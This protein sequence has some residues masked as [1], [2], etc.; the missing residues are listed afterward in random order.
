MKSLSEWVDALHMQAHPEGG[1]YA[2]VYRS[3]GQ[4]PQNALPEQFSGPRNYGTSIYFL[5]GPE[6]HSAFHRLQADEIWHFYAG[7]RL[8]VYVIHPNGN[9]QTLVLGNASEKGEVF[10]AVVPAGTWFAAQPVAGTY[11][12]VGCT[13]APGFDFEDFELAAK[14]D[15]SQEYPQ[16][17]DL[18]ARLS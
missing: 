6:D 12:L 17:A 5:L 14:D 7:G 15:L 8:E 9:L 16:H 1:Y 18:I 13:M 4:I 11:S 3:Q 2:E 10:Q